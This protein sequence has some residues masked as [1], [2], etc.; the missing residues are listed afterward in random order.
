MTK[1]VGQQK[2]TEELA[3]MTPTHPTQLAETSGPSPE[4]QDAVPEKDA[5]LNPVS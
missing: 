4:R 2:V 3:A 5:A 1:K